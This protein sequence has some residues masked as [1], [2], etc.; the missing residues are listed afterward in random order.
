LHLIQPDKI[1]LKENTDKNW[2]NCLKLLKE[3]D[4]FF[5]FFSKKMELLLND[6]K[7][8]N[9]NF[10]FT[11]SNNDN[12][13]NK[14]NINNTIHHDSNK[15]NKNKLYFSLQNS[16][17]VINNQLIDI[18]EEINDSLKLLSLRS[19]QLYLL[20]Q[21]RDLKNN[22]N[23]NANLNSNNEVMLSIKKAN[24]LKE[25]RIVLQNATEIVE[26]REK[27]Y[28]VSWQRIASWR[29]NPTVYRF[30]INFILK[31]L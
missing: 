16:K 31:L 2:K 24:F 29:E 18:I 1:H 25:S 5:S 15:K 8:N 11:Y 14:N 3:M 7:E 4:H 30:F 27:K 28:R 9:K 10:Q 6:I 19:L 20:Y 12:N 13:N 22:N 23:K 21:S 17:I 26:R